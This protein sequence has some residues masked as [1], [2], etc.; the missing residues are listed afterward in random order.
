M[1]HPGKIA[2]A[3]MAAQADGRPPGTLNTFHELR[4]G[5]FEASHDNFQRPE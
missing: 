2:L 3:V 1:G 5:H 4:N